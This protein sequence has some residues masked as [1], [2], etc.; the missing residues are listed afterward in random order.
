MDKQTTDY[1]T[2]IIAQAQAN[3]EQVQY[4]VDSTPKRAILRLKAVYDSYQILV[5]ELLSDEERKYRY[6]I[7]QE[8]WVEAGFDNAPDPRAIR[9]KY[10]KI[11]HEH[12]GELIPHLHLENKNEL[13]LTEDMTFERFVDWLKENLRR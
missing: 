6:Y 1:F 11:G 8:N 2:S 13:L 3:F 10:G 12:T 9:L 7:L 5:T 4:T